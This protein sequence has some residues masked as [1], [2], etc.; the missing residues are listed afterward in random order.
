VRLMPVRDYTTIT[1]KKETSK[2][3]GKIAASQGLSTQEL[4]SRL[5]KNEAI[6]PLFLKKFAVA[7][8]SGPFVR[9]SDNKL[10]RYFVVGKEEI[11][12]DE[13]TTQNLSD[14]TIKQ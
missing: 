3:F 4:L 2:A 14:I 9:K 13:W 6:L 8:V 5:C 7:K 1:V 12:T 10:Q 11:V